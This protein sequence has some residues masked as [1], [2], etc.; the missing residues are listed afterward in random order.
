MPYIKSCFGYTSQVVYCKY[1]LIFCL[2][3]ID[4]K[5]DYKAALSMHKRK[6]YTMGFSQKK[7]A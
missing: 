4:R 2:S 3:D 1:P 5:Q 7:Q 6:S